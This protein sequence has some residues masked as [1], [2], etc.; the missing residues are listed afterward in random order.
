MKNTELEQHLSSTREQL[1]KQIQ[2]NHDLTNDFSNYKQIASSGDDELR[3]SLKEAQEKLKQN[4]LASSKLAAQIEEAQRSLEKERKELADALDA[5]KR[6]ESDNKTLKVI[7][8]QIRPPLELTVF[9]G[10]VVTW[11]SFYSCS[12]NTSF[13]RSDYNHS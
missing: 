13:L 12:N 10:F 9:G 1:S 6:L 4:E 8:K 5:K 2:I 11:W 3:K 7:Y